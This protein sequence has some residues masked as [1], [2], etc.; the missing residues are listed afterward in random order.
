MSTTHVDLV[1]HILLILK[2]QSQESEPRNRDSRDILQNMEGRQHIYL[3]LVTAGLEH[4]CSVGSS[5]ERVVCM[6]LLV[7]DLCPYVPVEEQTWGDL[8]K[9][10]FMT[11]LLYSF[12]AGR[13][14]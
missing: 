12:L 14:S 7:H 5:S 4:H 9:N 2:L 8:L 10:L 13:S 1:S 6:A 3:Y 11:S